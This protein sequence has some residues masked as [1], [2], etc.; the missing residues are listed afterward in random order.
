[1]AW[2]ARHEHRRHVAIGSVWIDG[3]EAR[4]RNPDVL[5]QL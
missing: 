1:M 3:D 2:H 4:G 5:E